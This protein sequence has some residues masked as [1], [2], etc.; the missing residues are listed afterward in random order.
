MIDTFTEKIVRGPYKVRTSDGN[1]GIR[2]FRQFNSGMSI[3]YGKFFFRKKEAQNFI[4]N[5]NN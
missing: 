2:I 5:F 4:D 3:E 1:W